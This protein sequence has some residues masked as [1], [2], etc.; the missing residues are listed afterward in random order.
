MT[1]ISSLFCKV[2]PVQ[3]MIHDHNIEKLPFKY[4]IPTNAGLLQACIRRDKIITADK[5]CNL[6][7]RFNWLTPDIAASL[8]NLGIRPNQVQGK[9]LVI[10]Y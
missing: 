9:Y 2:Q 5:P 8:E 7:P 3:V 10:L 1:V 6:N 4:A